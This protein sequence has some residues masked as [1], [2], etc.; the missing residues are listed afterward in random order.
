[1][2]NKSPTRSIVGAESY[3]RCACFFPGLRGTLAR[4]TIGKRVIAVIAHKP[5]A[6][7]CQARDAMRCAR[8][9]ANVC[10]FPQFAPSVS[11]RLEQSAPGA[12]WTDLAINPDTGLRGAVATAPQ[13]VAMA[14]SLSLLWPQPLRHDAPS[15]FVPELRSCVFVLDSDSDNAP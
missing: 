12:F 10:V 13:T 11:L 8:H 2:K 7:D 9:Q 5:L 3:D 4:V 15:A 14:E 1:M 6:V